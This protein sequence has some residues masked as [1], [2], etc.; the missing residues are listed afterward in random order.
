MDNARRDEKSAGKA[1][2]P[3]GGGETVKNEIA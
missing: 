1:T 3:G 2:A